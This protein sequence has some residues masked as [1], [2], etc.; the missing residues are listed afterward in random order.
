MC[1]DPHAFS[2][3]VTGNVILKYSDRLSDVGGF[4]RRIG[5]SVRVSARDPRLPPLIPPPVKIQ[6]ASPVDED[7]DGLEPKQDIIDLFK[8]AS[9][10]HDRETNSSSIQNRQQGSRRWSH[11][12]SPKHKRDNF[13]PSIEQQSILNRMEERYQLRGSNVDEERYHQALGERKSIPAGGAC[14]QQGQDP[15]IHPSTWATANNPNRPYHQEQQPPPSRFDD[16][17]DEFVYKSK[18]IAHCDPSTSAM[19]SS[20]LCWQ[21]SVEGNHYVSCVVFLC[22]GMGLM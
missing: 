13:N 16:Q 20:Q 22:C 17:F 10:A 19:T 9:N 12:L 7:E 1:S 4:G 14:W 18:H 11:S 6:I 21:E 2:K 3:F 15:F 8:Q 5:G